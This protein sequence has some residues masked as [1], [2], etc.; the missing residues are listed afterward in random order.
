MPVDYKKYGSHWKKVVARIRARA[1]NKC[2]QCMVPNYAVGNRVDGVFYP[3]CGNAYCDQ[4]G[5]GE[6]SYKDAREV[7]IGATDAGDGEKYI[8]IVLTT[9]HLNHDVTDNTDENLKYLC[10]Q[11]HNRHDVAYRVQNR[12]SKQPTLF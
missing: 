11:C 7:A 8:V 1:Q 2:E 9:A 12:K 10:Q 5:R 6:L 3:I 4:A